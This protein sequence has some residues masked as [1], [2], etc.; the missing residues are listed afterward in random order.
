MQKKGGFF[1]FF[2]GSLMKIFHL[3]HPTKFLV[4]GFCAILSWIS[5]GFFSTCFFLNF[6]PSEIPG[7][8]QGFGAILG[9]FTAV[10]RMF[11]TIFTTFLAVFSAIFSEILASLSANFKGFLGFFRLNFFWIFP[12][13]FFPE[14]LGISVLAGLRC[15]SADFV[16]PANF[17]LHAGIL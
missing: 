17:S 14:I 13:I 6:F 2:C 16:C 15:F 11:L 7:I 9:C 1:F 12:D 3:I 4:Q 8:E 5:L 10:F